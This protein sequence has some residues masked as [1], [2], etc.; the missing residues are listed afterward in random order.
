MT[1]VHRFKCSAKRNAFKRLLV[2]KNLRNLN[3]E[4]DFPLKM[5][6]HITAREG[7]PRTGITVL[8]DQEA[9]AN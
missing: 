8:S 3:I 7:R 1:A 5:A 6:H 2:R 9:K 4:N